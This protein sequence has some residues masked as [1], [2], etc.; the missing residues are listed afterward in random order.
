MN[1]LGLLVLLTLAGL[2]EGTWDN[3]GGSCGLRAVVSDYGLMEY[4]Y[5]DVAYDS[6]MTRIVGGSGAL[7]GAWPWIVSIQHPWVPGLGHLCGGSLISTQWVLTA[8]HC[9][10]KFDNI[11][12]LSVVIGA[13]QLTQPGHGAKVRSVKK[14]LIHPYYNP[15]DMSYDIA[16]MQLDHPVQCSP[17]IQLA[18]VPDI[19]L[20]VSELQ[21][22]WIAGWGATAARSQDSAD[23]LQ[24]AKV[25]LIDV[26]LCNSSDW[27]AGEIHTHNLCA[28][29]PEG[30]IDT[31]QGDSGGPLMCQDNN[32]DSWWVVGLTSWGKGCAR[33]RQPGVYISTQ[34]FY[35]WILVHTGANTL[36]KGSPA[37]QTWSNFVTAHLPTLKPWPTHPLPTHMPWPAQPIPT[38][39]PWPTLLPTLNPW[40]TR[41][42]I[43]NTW[44]TPPPTPK[45]WPTQPPT[46]NPLPT[47]P[48]TPKPW[49]TRPPTYNT[50]PTHPPT[51][52]PWPTRPPT[53]NTLP[54]H[55]PTPKPW[56]TRPPTYNTLPTPIPSQKPWPTAPPTPEPTPLGEVSSCPFPV[57]KLVDFF[58]KVKKLLHDVLG[59]NTA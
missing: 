8:A 58:T 49:P 40:P 52:K 35:D 28:G 2:A 3:C 50:L 43:H 32:T 9:F 15:A 42:P 6:G 31:C 46:Y 11:S 41:P 5:G 13:T 18:C 16:L 22:C 55:P 17:Y 7:P 19:T 37:S 54:T 4:Y 27:Y 53:Y 23:Q 30:K 33:A 34:H 38:I 10:D 44:P 59:Q 48:P 36:G 24:E 47:H 1:W 14:V 20:K 26:Q 45:P 39:K 12:L 21:N 51:P 29:Y 56:P 25:Q 57:N